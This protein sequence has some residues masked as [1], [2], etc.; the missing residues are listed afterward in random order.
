MVLTQ[1]PSLFCSEVPILRMCNNGLGPYICFQRWSRA[2]S[3]MDGQT[4]ASATREFT[5][6]PS[7]NNW[8]STVQSS[9]QIAQGNL[10]YKGLFPLRKE[11]NPCRRYEFFETVLGRPY[12]P[13]T[14]V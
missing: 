9:S 13:S 11:Q 5:F 8:I 2:I 14:S 7:A 10:D 4:V 12:K 3:D 1:M 6:V